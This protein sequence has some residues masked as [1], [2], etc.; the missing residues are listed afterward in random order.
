MGDFGVLG[1]IIILANVTISIQGFNN[2]GAFEA[3][4]FQVGSVLQGKEYYRLLTSGFLHVSWSHLFFNMLSFY[5]F[6]GIIE[7]VVGPI[8][9]LVIYLGSLI[10]GNLL[11]L[12]IHRKHS[13]YRAV[14]ASGAVSGIIFAF[15]ALFPSQDL[16]LLFIPIGIP[17]WLFGL[18]FMAYSIYGIK[19][20]NDNIGHEAH[21]GGAIIG[22]AITL[23]MFPSL[24]LQST[25]PI[26]LVLV[27]TLVIIFLL[28][29]KPDILRFEKKFYQ[30]SEPS[31]K[32]LEEEYNSRKKEEQ[33]EINRILDKINTGGQDSLSK[34]ER[35][36][37]D[38]Y[39]RR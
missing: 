26:L 24:L 32:D 19:A 30:Y 13:Y 7:A 35:E 17:G 27:P 1:I 10:G 29:Y 20:Q 15:I 36:T 21:L 25:I 11:A 14:G 6:A 39:N 34:E 9:F 3:G 38:H 5:F 31:K 37:L 23:I 8:Y 33:D 16:S 2:R 22:L 12:L 18:L 4:T 28:I